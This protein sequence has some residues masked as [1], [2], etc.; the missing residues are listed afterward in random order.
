MA[1][2]HPGLASKMSFVPIFCQEIQKGKGQVL[3]I[4]YETASDTGDHFLLG[5][6]LAQLPGQGA[7][8]LEP[9]FTDNAVGFFCY[10]AEKSGNFAVVSGQWTV[11]E[12]VV[13]FLAISAA[14]QEQEQ[15]FIPCR[16]A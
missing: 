8:R 13:S 10:D 5:D 12:S 1:F 7:Q 14:L 16:F 15:G 9:A 6:G 3:L 4:F 2:Q 11:R